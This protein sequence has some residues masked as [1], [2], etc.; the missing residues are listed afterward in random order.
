MPEDTVIVGS[1]QR[2]Q[3]S[4]FGKN[5]LIVLVVFAILWAINGGYLSGILERKNAVADAGPKDSQNQNPGVPEISA[6]RTSDVL[7]YNEAIDKKDKKLCERI[8][9]ESLKSDC[10]KFFTVNGI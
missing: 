5:L 7:I 3:G 10:F 1:I 6:E 8:A 2:N 9:E 4:G